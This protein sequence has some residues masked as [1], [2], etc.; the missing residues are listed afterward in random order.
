MGTEILLLG[1]LAGITLLAYMVAINSHGPT[2]LSIS[3]LLATIMLAGT[4]WAIVQYVNSGAD[5]EKMQELRRLELEKKAA[6]ERIRTKEQE[7][8][9]NK[10][11]A[12][13]A[14]KLNDI[15][16]RGTGLAT[17]MMNVDLRD[18]SYNLETLIGRASAT[19][20][21]ATD[22]KKEFEGLTAE[23]DYFAQSMQLMNDAL[24]ELTEAGRYF[25]LYYRS[26]D[27]AQEELRER[28]L[29]QKARKAYENFKKAS[30]LVA[31]T[32]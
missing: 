26:E 22:L 30:S 19:K 6:E 17:T 23:D 31:S 7:L 15:I 27:S 3:Y 20:K 8:L 10:S 32:S 18:M 4:V 11:R 29:R 21:K 5:K 13:F 28:I 12:V 1:V 25:Y 2:R 24:S 9:E 16:N 14:A